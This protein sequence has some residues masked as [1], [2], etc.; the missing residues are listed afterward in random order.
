MAANFSGAIIVVD[1]ALVACTISQTTLDHNWIDAI[2]DTRSGCTTVGSTARWVGKPVAA[3]AASGCAA[4]GEIVANEFT[5][6]P[7]CV[8]RRRLSGDPAGGA[9]SCVKL[10]TWNLAGRDFYCLGSR[11]ARAGPVRPLL[12][13]E[14]RSVR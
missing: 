2:C 3:A 1:G 10:I 6:S 9:G 11:C 8:H 12:P 13:E 4:T 7:R 5:Y 14:G